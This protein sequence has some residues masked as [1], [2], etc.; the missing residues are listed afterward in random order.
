MIGKLNVIK[1]N[2]FEYLKNEKIIMQNLNHPF[3]INLSYFFCSP[4]HIFFAMKY[5]NGGELYIYLKKM[6]HFQEHIIKFYSCQIIIALEYLHSMNI[7]Y[8]DMKPE[9]I[10]LDERGDCALADFGISKVL[11]PLQATKSFVGTPEYLSPE[12]LQ[13]Q[14]HNKSVDIWSFGILLYEMAFGVTPFYNKSQNIMLKWIVNSDPAFNNSIIISKDLKDL[15]TKC[16]EK[17]Y[18]KRIGI[19]NTGD[20]KNHS[21]FKHIDWNMVVNKKQEPPI[22]PNQIKNEFKVQDIQIDNNQLAL[23]D[24]QIK[25][26]QENEEKFNKFDLQ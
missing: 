7:V 5:L 13:N 14:G 19:E 6:K 11:Q 15:I 26:L 22:K 2:T 1:E 17:N 18:K 20:I 12:V 10:L 24:R 21:F 3:L 16:L 9:N 25:I 23:S 4:E 8:R